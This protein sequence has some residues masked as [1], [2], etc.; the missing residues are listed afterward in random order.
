MKRILT[1]TLVLV[2]SNAVAQMT[3]DAARDSLVRK[4]HIGASTYLDQFVGHAGYGAMVITTSDGGAAAF[5]DGDEGLVLYKLDKNGKLQWKRKISRKGTELEPQCV[6]QDS[7]G[8]FYTFTLVYG[9][10]SWRGGCERIVY[11][12][13]TGT[14]GW[15]KQIGTCQLMN[16]PTV[17]YTHTLSDGRVAIRGH[18]VT[19]KPV[20]GKDPV[21][22]NWEGWIGSTGALT[23]KVGDVLNW[24]DEKWKKL[25][26]PEP[27]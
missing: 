18:I 24:S 14:I 25:F 23:Q 16:S 22:H 12:N 11:V 26:A 3:I 9:L 17:S 20:E 4:Y 15:D 6:V 8:N 7:K 1:I 5:G 21:Y 10:T 27:Q 2:A 13:K 19:E